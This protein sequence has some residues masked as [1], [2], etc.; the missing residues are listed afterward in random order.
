VILTLSGYCMQLTVESAKTCGVSNELTD[1][2]KLFAV[3]CMDIK[4][5]VSIA[6]H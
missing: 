5:V 1:D 3:Y 4:N 2:L 6:V